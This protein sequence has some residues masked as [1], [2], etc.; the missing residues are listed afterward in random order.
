MSAPSSECGA[1][2]GNSSAAAC[3]ETLSVPSNVLET[4]EGRASAPGEPSGVRI[5]SKHD[6]RVSH[7]LCAGCVCVKAQRGQLQHSINALNKMG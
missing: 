6:L 3:R 1:Q 5:G 7:P 2:T 4:E